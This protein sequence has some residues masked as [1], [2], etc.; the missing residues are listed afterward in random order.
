MT[1]KRSYRDIVIATETHI[2]HISNHLQN[3][4]THLERLNATE[5]KQNIA[6]VKN[7]TKIGLMWKIG[8]GLFSLLLLIIGIGLKLV[9]V[10]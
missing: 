2:A 6:I 3:I 5:G 1:D 8:G 9:G 4:D 10:Y 7:A